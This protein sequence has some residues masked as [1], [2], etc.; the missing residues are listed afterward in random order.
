MSSSECWLLCLR[1][2]DSLGVWLK[3]KE[4]EKKVEKEMKGQRNRAVLDLVVDASWSTALL[5]TPCILFF[6]SF[7][8]IWSL[9]LRCGL[10]VPLTEGSR[11]SAQSRARRSNRIESNRSDPLAFAH[12]D[13]NHTTRALQRTISSSFRQQAR[14][15][16][17][18][19][20]SPPVA[21]R[22]IQVLPS[23]PSAPL[24]L[25]SASLP[26]RADRTLRS[27]T[28]K[29]STQPPPSPTPPSTAPHHVRH[30]RLHSQQRGRG[31]RGLSAAAAA[32]AAA[33]P[34]RRTGKADH[35]KQG[36]QPHA[37]LG[38]SV[39]NRGTARW[40]RRGQS[41]AV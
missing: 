2:V 41:R 19:Q 30:P 15:L 39:E 25:S 12:S 18:S 6:C 16:N 26:L 31:Q 9:F 20:Q 17:H 13:H 22:R 32:R 27:T 38:K 37:W 23:A 10:S 24:S 3:Q 35:G 8:F 36:I 1:C 21:R 4:E 40:R 7:S 5:P 34:R 11:S 33:P 28:P 29:R 14:T